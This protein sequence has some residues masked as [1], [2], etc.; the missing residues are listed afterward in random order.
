MKVLVTAASKYGATTEIAEAIGRALT[1][2]GIDVTVSSIAQ[3]KEIESYDRP[4]AAATWLFPRA[5]AGRGGPGSSARSGRTA[6]R[7]L[8]CAGAPAPTSPRRSGS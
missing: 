8:A 5:T 2:R 3:V 6:P 4:V 7:G 1:E